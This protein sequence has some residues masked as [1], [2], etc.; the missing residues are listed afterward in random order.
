[1][2]DIMYGSSIEDC[3]NKN[4]NGLYLFKLKTKNYEH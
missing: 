1:M 3:L 2:R 4:N